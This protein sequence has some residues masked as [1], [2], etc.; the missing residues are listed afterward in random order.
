MWLHGDGWR[1]AQAEGNRARP[2]MP[3]VLAVCRNTGCHRFAPLINLPHPNRG[4]PSGIDLNQAAAGCSMGCGHCIS[5]F[6]KAEEIRNR[7]R[8]DRIV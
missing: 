6:G 5:T 3:A 7:N 8:N 2:Y 1:G 4:M